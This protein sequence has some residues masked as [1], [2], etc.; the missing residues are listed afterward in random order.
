[1]PRLPGTY[2]LECTHFLH[3]FFGMHGTIEVT[4]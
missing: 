3:S 4:P 2:H 1:V